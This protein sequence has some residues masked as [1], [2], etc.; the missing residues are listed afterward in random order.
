MFGSLSTIIS[1]HMYVSVHMHVL[2]VCMNVYGEKN[3]QEWQDDSNTP[4]Y[5]PPPRF[6]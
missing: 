5:E 6:N 3:L 4:F 2:H 1:V